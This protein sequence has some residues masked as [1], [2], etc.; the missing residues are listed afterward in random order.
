MNSPRFP[1]LA[2]ALLLSGGLG[3][4]GARLLSATLDGKPL[5]TEPSAGPFLEAGSE[6]GLPVWLTYLDL[7]PRT[8]RVVTLRLDEPVTAGT[9]RVLEQPLARP[10]TSHVTLRGC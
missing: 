8:S 1:W 9:P 3:F 5:T 7:P 2:S 6:A 4:L 10:L